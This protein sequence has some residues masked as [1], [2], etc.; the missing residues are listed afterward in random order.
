MSVCCLCV[1]GSF[2]YREY[3]PSTSPLECIKEKQLNF[4]QRRI[5]THGKS[6]LFDSKDGKQGLS[7]FL[8]DR[9]KTD[10]H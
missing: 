4:Q 8:K 7:E 1:K 5:F 6:D 2:E 10:H 9:T 3:N